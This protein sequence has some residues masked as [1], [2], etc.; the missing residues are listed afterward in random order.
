MAVKLYEK[1]DHGPD[2]LIAIVVIAM[3]LL[4]TSKCHAQQ[5][6]AIDTMVC[7]VECI[8]QIVQQPSSNG[9]T[10]KYMAVYVDKSAGFSEVIPIS[11]SVVDYISTCKQFSITPNIGIRL[12]NGVITS[13]V[14]YKIKFVHR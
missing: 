2:L 11:K 5:K 4:L 6:A 3:L 13:I 14:R 9:K 8:K 10:V 1:P 12:R 7:K